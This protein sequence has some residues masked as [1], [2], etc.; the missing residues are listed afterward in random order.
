[1]LKHSQDHNR[2]LRK[3]KIFQNTLE[4]TDQK[5]VNIS[6]YNVLTEHNYCHVG[7]KK[8]CRWPD[9]KISS[10]NSIEIL[11]DKST[12]DYRDSDSLPDYLKGFISSSD[13]EYEEENNKQVKSISLLLKM[14]LKKELATKVYFIPLS[15]KLIKCILPFIYLLLIG[16][17][18]NKCRKFIIKKFK[19]KRCKS[20]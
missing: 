18:K 14:E 5:M 12:N 20:G 3:R 8:N 4:E 2:I 9:T 11:L 17:T 6:D 10:K 1:M 7:G 16:T 15:F 19:F 13:E